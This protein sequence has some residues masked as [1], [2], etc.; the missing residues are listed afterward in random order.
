MPPNYSVINGEAE[1]VLEV[2]LPTVES[3]AELDCDLEEDFLFVLTWGTETSGE[4]EADRCLS[5]QLVAVEEPT[6]CR[7]DRVSHVL[8]L[9]FPRLLESPAAAPEEEPQKQN[10]ESPDV[11]DAPTNNLRPQVFLQFEFGPL[12]ERQEGRVVIELF[13]DVC[14]KTAENFRCLCTGEKGADLHYKGSSIHHIFPTWVLEGGSL[15]MEGGTLLSAPRLSGRSIYGEPFTDESPGSSRSGPGAVS[16]HSTSDGLMSSMFYI[17]LRH[18]DHLD[19]K[20]IMFGRVIDGMETV[21][22]L[23][24]TEREARPPAPGTTLIVRE[25]D[26]AVIHPVNQVEIVDCGELAMVDRC[27]TDD[28]TS[29]TND[30][31]EWADYPQDT[32][33]DNPGQ[34]LAAARKIHQC[35][36]LALE[37]KDL[38]K[39]EFKF[40][41]SLRY[42]ERAA[43]CGD[44]TQQ[45]DVFLDRAICRYKAGQFPAALE[46]CDLVLQGNASNV[47]ALYWRASSL[48]D[49]PTRENQ[50]TTACLNEA[51]K[52]LDTGS[53]LTNGKDQRFIT[54]LKEVRKRIKQ[55]Q[56]KEKN[57]YASMFK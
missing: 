3:A 54:K 29:A 42:I 17:E 18:C 11:A 4:L 50:S 20:N 2:E 57:F 36:Q 19:G 53:T 55:G 14:P 46:D 30:G 48:L 5:I 16:M 8:S 52:D 37:Q 39:A 43:V 41:K 27:T 45:L 24:E 32:L 26:N 49:G 28:L 6:S 21:R 38:N 25:T 23:E 33:I 13:S 12:S 31:D 1:V 51:A 22:A 7:F 34:L 10:L 40:T 44:T 56:K 15:G 9:V 35:G 47:E